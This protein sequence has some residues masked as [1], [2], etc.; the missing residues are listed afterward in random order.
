M[1]KQVEF[2][3]EVDQLKRER[4][5][6]LE[7]QQHTESQYST[8]RKTMT[9]N[10]EDSRRRQSLLEE[11]IREL[12]TERTKLVNGSAS[13]LSSGGSGPA[14]MTLVPAPAPPPP[15]P[16]PPPPMATPAPPPPPPPGPPP[17][18]LGGPPGPPP[19]PMTKT[20]PNLT[21]RRPIQTTYKLPTVH[22]V[23]M[24]PNDTKDTIWYALNQKI[25]NHAK[26][27]PPI[28]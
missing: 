10:E 24:K 9:N 8:L 18:P 17:P 23:A 12:E 1:A 28:I 11:K 16:P 2:E 22:W 6:I 15:P 4:D 25:M 21:I 5:Q 14:T 20:D 19:P 7:K 3:N 13:S 26:L 27:T